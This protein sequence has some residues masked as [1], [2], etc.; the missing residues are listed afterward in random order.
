VPPER[1]PSPPALV[2]AFGHALRSLRGVEERKMFGWPAI[3]VSGNMIAGLIRD[4]MILRL[5]VEDADRF[6]GLPRARPFV[7]MGGRRMKQWVVVP[8][9]VVS[10][11][12]RLTTWLARALAHGRALPPKTRNAGTRRG[13]RRVER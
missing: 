9:A 4:Q 6:L 2:R 12:A 11:P 8:P 7:A 10:S 13:S 5:S 1:K 3:F